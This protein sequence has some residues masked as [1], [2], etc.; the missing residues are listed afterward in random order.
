MTVLLDKQIGHGEAQVQYGSGEK[1]R[2]QALALSIDQF[3]QDLLPPLA[4]LRETVFLATQ[5]PEVDA[6][7]K[8]AE[9]FRFTAKMR[10]TIDKAIGIFLDA[11]AGPD[12]TRKGYVNGGIESDTPDGVL[13]QRQIMSYSV[14]LRRASD[15][16][17]AAQTLV[18][19]RD[20]PAVLEMLNGA[21]SRLSQNGTLRL[22]GVRDEIHGILT[23]GTDAGLSP[24]DVGR[25]LAKQFDQYSGYEF[26][27]LARTE[28]AF[29]AEA[30]NREQMMDFG[31]T[32]VVWLLSAGACELC[33]AYENQVIE[34][35]DVS[36]QP[37]IHPND[38]C[39]TAPYLGGPI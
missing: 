26:E 21:F 10:R 3:Y 29:A 15:L 1:P 33:Q 27:R 31:V 20:D 9:P 36:N 2:Y 24:L 8:A 38:M 11:M 5:L 39:S 28:A 37:P 6:V 13:Q 7:E 12:R 34:I 32:H 18:P 14:G 16:L 17:G 19:A 35:E 25:Q 30:G 22:E 4:D 23:S